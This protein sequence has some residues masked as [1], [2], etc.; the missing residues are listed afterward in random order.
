MTSPDLD[1]KISYDINTDITGSNKL[2]EPNSFE[3]YL[4]EN[5]DLNSLIAFNYMSECLKSVVLTGDLCDLYL[6]E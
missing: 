5:F 2:K 1:L 6:R 3:K 4:N